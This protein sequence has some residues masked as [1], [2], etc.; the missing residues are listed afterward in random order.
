MKKKLGITSDCTCDM[1]EELLEQYD[2]EV[3]YF[4]INTDHGSFKDMQEITA[5][6]VV[7][8]FANGGKQISTVAPAV[9][10][11]ADFF[12]KML[13]KYEQIIHIT[14]CATL[15]KSYENALAASQ[16]F[17]GRV[18]VFN[19]NHLSTGIAHF[20]IRATEMVREGK[21]SDDILAN[22][23]NMINKVSTSFIAENADYLYRT[24]RVNKFVRFACSTFNIHPVLFVKNGKIKLKTV[25][26]GD[27]D[28]SVL[29]YVR[30]ELSRPGKIDRK[31][32]FITYCTCPIR[33]LNKIKK[34]VREICPFDEV[35]EAT[36]S[37]TITS[38]CGANT[39][40]VLFV[41][42]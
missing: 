12:E 2:V 25:Q 24:G 3:I 33:V 37:A 10:E 17:D 7:E 29:R 26:I 30:K 20:V 32:V 21:T 22:L 5:S 9:Y 36:A 18:K 14:I 16:R 19:T 15:S 6:N 28:K 11:Y 23:E 40:G 39:V 42:K 31:R 38:N 8:Y 41:R 34:Q 4:Y 35:L 1:S 13:H 27:Y